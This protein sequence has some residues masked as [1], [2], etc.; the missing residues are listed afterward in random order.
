MK[1]KTPAASVILMLILCSSKPI[2][3]E[4]NIS[5]ENE[6][7]SSVHSAEQTIEHHNKNIDLKIQ[8]DGEQIIVDASFTVPVMPS[9]A[10]AV[11]TDFD[12]IP[13]FIT[14]IQ[15]SKITHR[16]GNHLQV[17]QKGATKYGPLTFSFESVRKINFPS[18]GL[19]H[20]L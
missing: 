14:G 13:N 6:R 2:L 19:N 10:W 15:S 7:A 12:N 17:S 20:R 4:R 5:S 8:N 3:A 18:Q 16:N 1:E 9:Q 11:L